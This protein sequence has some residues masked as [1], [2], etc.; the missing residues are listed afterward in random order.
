MTTAKSTGNTT[1]APP[2]SLLSDEICKTRPGQWECSPIIPPMALDDIR[3]AQDVAI[4]QGFL[5]RRCCL[6]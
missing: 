3:M 1:L 2:V 4:G 5:E 6:S